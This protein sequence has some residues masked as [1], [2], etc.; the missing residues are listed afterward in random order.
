M[1]RPMLE[2]LV[3]QDMK[4]KKAILAGLALVASQLGAF[5]QDP[6]ARFP[7]G[8]VIQEPE[9]LYSK[10][11][12]LTVDLSYQ[13]SPDETDNPKYCFIN[14]DGSQSPTLHVQPGDT[15]V[16]NLT[17]LVPETA[18][19]MPDMP[20]MDISKAG[21]GGCGALN[22]TSASVNLH[23]HGTNTPPIC[24]QDEVIKTIINT[25]ETFRYEVHFPKN[26][27]PGLYWYHPHI[28]GLATASVQGGA[29]GVIVV[30]GI[31]NV[32]PEVAGLPQE[33][34]VVRD[35]KPANPPPKRHGQR[36][37][38]A[39]D[40]AAADL[41]VNYV[42]VGSP[43]FIPAEYVM[44]PGEKQFWRL[45]NSAAVT[46]LDIQ[47]LY[48]GVPQPLEIISLD[49]IALGSQTGSGEAR[50]IT[51]TDLL[52][53]PAGRAE[54]IVTGP[55]STARVARLVTRKVD[56]GPGGDP[57]PLRPLFNISTSTTTNSANRRLPEVSGPPP[58][59]RFAGL[60][61]AKPVKTR[62]LYFSED[63]T[64]FYITVDGQTPK[65]Y[66]MDDPPAIVTTQGSVE[67]WIIQN[68][69][70]EN[71]EFHMH[72][73][74]F[75]LLQRNGK[76]VP[77]TERQMLDTVDIPYWSG[78][79]PYPS[80]TVRMDFRGPDVGDFVYH[81]HIL[82]HEDGGMMAIIRVLPRNGSGSA[83]AK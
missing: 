16:I 8:S 59:Q 39:D 24:H 73:I 77:A 42:P 38:P 35:N 55:A 27:P 83:K 62:T 7:A 20:G 41:S 25:G 23:Y 71:H 78:T 45:V 60:F 68:R 34:I 54:F 66:S 80:V 53:P 3:W 63:D 44:Q 70:N 32:N 79:G 15:L 67:D 57:D 19:K 21:E 12:V 37:K 82:D 9:D 43:A 50:S 49:S 65:P 47:L 81:C 22:M 58:A 51:K 33:L 4:S 31:E 10:D 26:E 6:C 72:Q 36:H 11:G 29:T 74:H 1:A 48:D 76:P 56:T 52:I 75:G 64:N 61:D 17:N 46:I 5:A 40:D 18:G 14:S 69:A 2:K 30:E 28:H 13:T